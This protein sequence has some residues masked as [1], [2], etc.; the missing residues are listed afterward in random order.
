MKEEHRVFWIDPELHSDQH[1]FLA[2][3]MQE[4]EERIQRKKRIEEKIAGSLVL[5]FILMTI[6]LIGAGALDW[7]RKHLN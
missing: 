3:L 1:A 5:S 7:M 2:L 6:G 4:R